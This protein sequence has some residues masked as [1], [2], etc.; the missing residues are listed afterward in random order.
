MLLKV[1]GEA[2][3]EATV[4]YREAQPFETIGGIMKVLGIGEKTFESVKDHI[5]VEGTA[6]E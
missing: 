6:D 3:A 4:E 1:L 5:A 2:R